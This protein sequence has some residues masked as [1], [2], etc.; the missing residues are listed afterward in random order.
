VV[1]VDERGQATRLVDG[2]ELGDCGLTGLTVVGR[3]LH[4]TLSGS[5]WRDDEAILARDGTLLV[6]KLR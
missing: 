4:V 2:I 5:S 3:R 6:Q 1:L